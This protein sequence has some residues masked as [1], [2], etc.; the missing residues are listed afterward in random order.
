[1]YCVIG[2]SDS[3]LHR[4]STDSLICRYRRHQ[5]NSS[6]SVPFYPSPERHVLFTVCGPEICRS[7]VSMSPFHQWT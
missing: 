5:E 3:S 4:E 7:P 2:A 1:M 6:K